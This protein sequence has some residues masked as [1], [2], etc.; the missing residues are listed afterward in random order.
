MRQEKP[1]I[2]FSMD[3]D[4]AHDY[5]LEYALALFKKHSLAVTVFATHGT[6]LLEKMNKHLEVGIHPDFLNCEDHAFT[7]NKMLTMYPNARGVRAHNLFEY[8]RLLK[9]YKKGGINWDSSQLLY[10]CPFIQPYRHPSGLVRLPIFWEDDDY[11]SFNPRW[12]IGSLGLERPGVKC[13]DFHP[14][15]LYLNSFSMNAYNK[16]REG[17]FS[18]QVLQ[19]YRRNE[20]SKGVLFFF[21][22]LCGY[23]R[24]H[25]LQCAT[26]GE[27]CAWV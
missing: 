22:L 24:A 20:R 11:L 17:G 9:L 26:I 18:R 1:V 21:E 25:K 7:I 8:S 16:A 19:R 5:V 14:I 6:K 13:F 23:I 2:V 15:H 12:D 4:W 3:T 27:V 10:L